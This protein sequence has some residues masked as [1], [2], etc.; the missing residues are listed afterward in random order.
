MRI[1]YDLVRDGLSAIN[2]AADRLNAARDQVATGRRINSTSDDPLGAEQ[3]IGDRGL[4]AGLDAYTRARDSASA[5][6]AAADSVLS[7]MTDK[8]TSAI[9]AGS[10][11]R[12][13]TATASARA[14]ASAAVRG[15][16]DSL[17]ADLNTSFNGSYLFSGTAVDTPAYALVGGVWT[18][19]GDHAATQVEVEKGRLVATTFDGDALA[20][21]ADSMD[22]LT[23]LDGLAT[24]IDAGDNDAIGTALGALD[25]AF[26][27]VL[28]AQGRL[29]ADER[30]V[31]E[32]AARLSA[33]RLAADTRRSKVEDANVAEAI[34]RLTSADNAYRAALGAVSSAERQSL[35]DYLR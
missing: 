20:R 16:R 30:G 33:L 24:A 15:L 26:D 22:L 7:G 11:V 12:G 27:R 29:G 35:L 13:T 23:A 5:R 10:G 34:A 1:I 32:A 25:R 3:A 9:V 21:G 4:V 28:Q 14:A 8:I 6:L 17:A 19:Q 31:D 18:Y 2:T